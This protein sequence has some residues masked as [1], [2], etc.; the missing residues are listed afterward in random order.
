M[1]EKWSRYLFHFLILWAVN[2]TAFFIAPDG[3]VSQWIT[4]SEEKISKL[5]KIPIVIKHDWYQTESHVCVTV[6]AKNLN[7]AAVTVDFTASTVGS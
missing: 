1:P 4:W 7:P 5:K 6:L 3:G 2:A